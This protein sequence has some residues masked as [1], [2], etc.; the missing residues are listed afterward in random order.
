[1]GLDYTETSVGFCERGTIPNF[2]VFRGNTGKLIDLNGAIPEWQ[3]NMIYVLSSLTGTLIMIPEEYSLSPA[4]PNPFNSVTTLSYGLPQ[5]THVNIKVYDIL[6]KEVV[7]LI[8]TIQPV[9]YHKY[10]W[11]AD[12]QASGV[13][14]ISMKE[15]SFHK[16]Q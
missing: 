7:E 12:K 2:K 5:D 3:S 4:Y 16:N 9:G 8:N 11:N 10:V 15:G 13:Y 6:G 14:F 1:M